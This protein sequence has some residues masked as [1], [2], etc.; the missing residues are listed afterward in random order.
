MAHILLLGATGY[1]GGRLLPRLIQ[2]GHDV[3][4]LVRNPHK[5]PPEDAEQALLYQGDVLKPE[6]LPVAFA[7]TEIVFYLVHSMSGGNEDFERQDRAAAAYV[8]G[9][10]RAAGVQRIIYLGGLG[11]RNSDQTPHLRSR[12]EVGDILRSSGIPVTEFRAAVIVGSGSASFEMLHHLVNRLP[13]MITPRWVSVRTQ[14]LAI[15]DLLSYLLDA[16]DRPESAGEVIDI[17]GPEVL[18]YRDMMLTVA[19]V[20]GLRRAVLPVPVL[21]PKLSSYWVNLVTPIPFSL[22]RSLI[23]S[24]RSETICENDSAARL[25]DIRPMR[26]ED[27]VRRALQ[28]VQTATVETT[29]TSAG[30]PPVPQPLDPSHFRIDQQV[31]SCD[32]APDTLFR[33]VS[34]IGGENGWYFANILWRMRGFLDKQMGGVGLRRGRRHPTDMHVGEALDFWR[35]EEIDSGRRLLLRAEMKVWGRAWLEFRVEPKEDGTSRLFQT[36]RYYPRGITG[37]LYWYS[38][39]PL[40]VLVF[41]G[42][43]R[44]IARKAEEMGKER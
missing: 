15:A 38:V 36:A 4:C 22:A 34:S 40:H 30:S 31:V 3:R 28:K 7:G 29:W 9:A 33:V 20:L 8:A 1:I 42:M 41:R 32:A 10:A 16:V 17:G 19:R 6:T 24:V 44:A 23:E 43:A 25:F 13:V 5:I 21:T 37:L 11:E 26:F 14:P 27:A 18:T 35:V 2:R 12:H 39:Y